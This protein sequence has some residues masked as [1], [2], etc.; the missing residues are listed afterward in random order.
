MKHLFI[1]CFAFLGL[2]VSA[3]TDMEVLKIWDS[4]PHN[5]FTDLVRYRGAFYCTFREGVSHVPKGRPENGKIRILKSADGIRWKSVALLAN[6]QYDLRDPKVSVTPDN[7]LMVIMGG[8]DYTTGSLLGCLTH[9]SFSKNGKDFS[10][11]QPVKISP[12]VKTAYDWIW[13][14]TWQDGLGYGVVYQPKQPDGEFAIQ[15][16]KTTDGIRYEGVSR[17]NVTGKPNESTVRFEGDRMYIV[18]RREAQGTNGLLGVSNPPYQ[19]WVW[20]D[21]GLK[22][23]GPEFLFTAPGHIAMGTRLYRPAEQ[24]SAKTGI[25]YMNT[26]GLTEAILELPS[27]GDTSYPGMVLYRGKLYLSYYSSHE[28]KTSIYLASLSL[29]D[30]QP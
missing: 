20:I 19:D 6:E 14:V 30:Q 29:E 16:L 26:A 21:L 13:R 27:G 2:S 8:S 22:V 23:G 25:V 12:E 7:R 17:L 18:V 11:P 10:V 4:A 3:Q 24:G 28:N 5:A 15:L 9:V 1:L